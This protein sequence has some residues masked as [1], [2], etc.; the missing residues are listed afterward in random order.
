MFTRSI[1]DFKSI[2]EGDNIRDGTSLKNFRTWGKTEGVLAALKT[3][4]KNGISD[5]N[6]TKLARI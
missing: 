6:A 3:D 2:F 4:V 5:D 1:E